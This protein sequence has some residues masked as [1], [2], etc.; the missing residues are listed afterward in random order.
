[1][2]DGF[3]THFISDVLQELFDNAV[4]HHV[5]QNQCVEIW[6][7][8]WKRW[9]AWYAWKDTRCPVGAVMTPQGLQFMERSNEL[10]ANFS[11]TVLGRRFAKVHPKHHSLLCSMQE[12]YDG[13]KDRRGF[14]DAMIIAGYKHHLST[15]IVQREMTADWLDQSTPWIV[16]Y[17]D[18]QR[19]PD[20]EAASEAGAQEA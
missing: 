4:R 11:W 6:D 2:I 12:A 9:Q 20:Q 10:A 8:K 13:A 1:M 16:R 3:L 7:V 17:R 14:A 19:E 15:A 5:D 18:G